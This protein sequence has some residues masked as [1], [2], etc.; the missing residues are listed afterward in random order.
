M[1]E[2]TEWAKLDG[3]AKSTRPHIEV[4]CDTKYGVYVYARVAGN[5]VVPPISKFHRGEDLILETQVDGESMKLA[6][7]P[8]DALRLANWIIK[9]FSEPQLVEL[10]ASLEEDTAKDDDVPF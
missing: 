1:S 3:L 4:V 10:G 2:A 8:T 9:H 6:V 5:E 7:S